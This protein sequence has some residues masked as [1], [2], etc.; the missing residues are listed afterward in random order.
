MRPAF[1]TLRE[2]QCV[3]GWSIRWVFKMRHQGKTLR[4]MSGSSLRAKTVSQ[5]TRSKS[6]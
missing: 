5:R 2:I 3:Q 6:L 1:N 4:V